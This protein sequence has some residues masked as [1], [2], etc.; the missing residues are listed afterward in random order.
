MSNDLALRTDIEAELEFEPSLTAAGIGVAVKDGVATL[1]GHVPSYFEKLAAERATGRVKG[2]R[3]VAE[4]LEVR[5]PFD[6]KHD[7]E[8]I[9]RRASNILE[10]GTFPSVKADH[11]KVDKGWVTLSGEVDWQYQKESAADAVRRLAGVSGVS[12]LITI[13][14]HVTA[15]DVQDRISKAYRRNAELESAGIKVS[16][17]GGKVSLSGKVHAWNDRRTAENAAW[18][19]SSVT[20]VIDNLVVV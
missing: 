9:A 18:A 10:W 7:D 14:P 20:Q 16:V 5:L 19:V 11:V 6:V 13:R 4:E 17:D 12:N 2:V 1:T 8:E 15:G 3:A